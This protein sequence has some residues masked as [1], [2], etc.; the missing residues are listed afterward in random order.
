[1]KAGSVVRASIYLLVS[2]AILMTWSLHSKGYRVTAERLPAPTV[3]KR[4]LLIG[5]SDYCPAKAAAAECSSTNPKG[6]YWWNLHTADEV[7]MLA[8][9]LKDHYKFDEVTVLKTNADTTHRSIVDHFRKLLVEPTHEGDIAYFHFSGHGQQVPDD[10]DPGDIEPDGMDETIIPSDYVSRQ[11]PAKNIRDDEIGKLLDELSTR[12]PG[13]V[14]ISLDSCFSGTATRGGDE[15]LVP[16]GEGWH[17]PMPKRGEDRGDDDVGTGL[18]RGG[19]APMN[20][21]F[22]SAASPRQVANEAIRE[23]VDS[24]GK[25]TPVLMGAFTMALA[26]ALSQATET[27]SYRDLYYQVCAKVTA[28]TRG[29]QV[30]QIEGLLDTTLMNGSAVHVDPFILLRNGTNGTTM[31]EAGKLQG[32]TA[33][34]KYLICPAGTLT[35]KD[36]TSPVAEASVAD[37]YQTESVLNTKGKK[38][39]VDAAKPF[40]AFETEHAFDFSALKVT[41]ADLAAVD[42]GRDAAILVSKFALAD[43]TTRRGTADYDILIRPASESDRNLEGLPADFKGVVLQRPDGTIVAKPPAGPDLGKN[44]QE[45]LKN[46]I[47]W[48]T[49]ANMTPVNTEIKIDARLYLTDGTR[50]EAKVFHESAAGQALV[51]A[52]KKSSAN[53]NL[54]FEVDKYV[55]LEVKN[56]NSYSVYVTVLDLSPDGVIAAAFPN[57][58]AGFPTNNEI[59][60][61]DTLR[62]P[63]HLTPPV[64]A[65][66]FKILVTKQNTDFSPLVTPALADRAASRGDEEGIR[67]GETHSLGQ[68]FSALNDP[69][70]KGRSTLRGVE[71]VAAD[72]E[73]WTSQSITFTVRKK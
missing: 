8:N 64:G 13:N 4:A 49:V 12:K 9:I 29:R 48:K 14:T 47:R 35:K 28:G 59:A 25:K 22:L 61:G 33:G 5:V 11:D 15:V 27:T 62:L 66:M 19:Q 34:S 16:R 53:N 71:P 7:D 57:Y 70:N 60:A 55:W 21:V 31:L 17:G 3:K 50:D 65:E 52:A 73:N 51:E 42:G 37:I 20:Y 72:P 41:V 63:F 2:V 10:G 39:T 6:K 44:I 32:M 24:A 69:D 54:N 56:P 46:E 23:T 30:P 68:I 36:C 43:T 1:M 38:I 67:G 58:A 18:T 45:A 26:D 40:R